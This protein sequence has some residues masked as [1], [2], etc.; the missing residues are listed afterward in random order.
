MKLKKKLQ[1]YTKDFELYGLMIIGPVEHK[2]NI[3]FKNMDDSESYLNATDV[4]YDSEYPGPRNVFGI[5][6]MLLP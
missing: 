2:T 1:D 4:D 6:L 5:E 3:R